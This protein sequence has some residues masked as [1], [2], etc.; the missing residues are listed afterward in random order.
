[1]K[2]LSII[3]AMLCFVTAVSYAQQQSDP[4]PYNKEKL[5]S[6]F[7]N[8]PRLFDNMPKRITP[9]VVPSPD[10]GYTLREQPFSEKT[11]SFE[12]YNPGATVINKTNRG[13]IYNI[14][15]D[16]MAV[17]VPNM[18]A[19]E[20]MQGSNPRYK[21]AADSKMPNPLNRKKTN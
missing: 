11:S 20:N 8:I 21:P 15:L 6:L 14:P 7:G 17:L 2:R 4:L 5:D 19:V 12:T 10:G 1:M 3:T 9:L 18:Y 13:I 16:N